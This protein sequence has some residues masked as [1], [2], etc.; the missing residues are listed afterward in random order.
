MGVD[1]DALFGW[2]I[3]ANAMQA[4]D[5]GGS[6]ITIPIRPFLGVM[7]NAPA[8]PGPL[9]TAPPRRVGGN[10]DCKE[11][12]AGSTLFLPVEVS[13]A[14]FS[15]GDGHAVQG[16]GEAGQTGMECPMERIELQLSLRNGTA[17]PGPQA[18]TPAGYVV[19]GIGATLDDA[20]AMALDG[21]LL[22]ITEEYGIERPEA[23]ALSSLLVDLRVT[24][25]VNGTVGVHAILA[26]NTLKR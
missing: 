18:R 20:T 16:D 12:V 3:D 24:Q 25:I 8:E 23:L 11:L 10:L 26:H 22:H 4:T 14:L 13:G 7:G 1:R 21:M 17:L 19:M 2:R 15:L 6:R 5:R 9:K